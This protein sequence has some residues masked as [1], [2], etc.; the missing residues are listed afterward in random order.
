[1]YKIE[2]VVKNETGLHARPASMFV[3]EANKFTSEILVTKD[4]NEYNAKSILGLLTMGAKKGDKIT[5]KAEG[6]DEREAVDALI[7][8]VESNFGE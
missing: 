5:I 2:V 6:E 3:K 1:M 8:L 7:S 4:V